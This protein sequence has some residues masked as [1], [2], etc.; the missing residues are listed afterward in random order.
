MRAQCCKCL[1]KTNLLQA[2]W[3]LLQAPSNNRIFRVGLYLHNVLNCSAAE[4]AKRQEAARIPF[5]LSE[6]R[7]RPQWDTERYKIARSSHLGMGL[8]ACTGFDN[9]T[10][11]HNSILGH[12][13]S[14]RSGL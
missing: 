2:L 7:E 8:Q 10:G 11:F 5:D 4:R 1:F 12:W 9:D 13:A 3:P 6:N 14:Q